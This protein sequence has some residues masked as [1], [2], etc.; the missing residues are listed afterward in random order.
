MKVDNIGVRPDPRDPRR[1]MAVLLDYGNSRM[2]VGLVEYITFEVRLCGGCLGVLLSLV[3]HPDV[4]T[5]CF[6]AVVHLAG[7]V[8]TALGSGAGTTH[9][10]LVAV[11][12]GV[13]PTGHQ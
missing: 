8:S 1:P 9:P 2:I 5:V 7:C 12:H 6:Q 4:D 11:P 13:T 10:N 3:P